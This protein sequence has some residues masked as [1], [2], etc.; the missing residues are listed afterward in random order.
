MLSVVARLLVLGDRL[1]P[2]GPVRL[3]YGPNDWYA[4]QFAL[5]VAGPWRRCGTLLTKSDMQA[6]TDLAGNLV[7]WMSPGDWA[8]SMER[9]KVDR[10]A[11]QRRLDEKRLADQLAYDAAQKAYWESE[12]AVRE[13]RGGN[14][15]SGAPLRT[16]YMCDGVGMVYKGG[17]SESYSSWV[18]D[19]SGVSHYVTGTRR[20]S[21]ERVT[22][23]CCGGA[24]ER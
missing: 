21:S 3:T 18:T 23:D 13:S 8:Q 10:L 17:G 1:V 20:V 4:G 19:S 16:C 12:Q 6:I 14:D 2:D 11:E 22:C 9:M 7:P 24:G 5:G 15:G